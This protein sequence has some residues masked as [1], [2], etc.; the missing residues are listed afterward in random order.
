MQILRRLFAS[1][2][3]ASWYASRRI[4]ARCQQQHFFSMPDSPPIRP[5][6]RRWRAWVASYALAAMVWPALGPLPW[7]DLDFAPTEQAAALP[8]AASPEN[9]AHKHRTDAAQIPGSP[10]H[11]ADHDCF[12][13]QVLKHLARCVLALPAAPAVPALSGCPVAPPSRAVAQTA[14]RSAALPP[15]R[16]PPLRLS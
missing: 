5:S 7:L 2:A 9:A 11:P 3:P 4:D 13:C 6:R 1:S 10:T 16:G 14:P 12:Q 8:P 15:A